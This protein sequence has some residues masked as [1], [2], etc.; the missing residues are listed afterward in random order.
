MR[1]SVGADLAGGHRR[2]VLSI[3]AAHLPQ[4]SMAWVFGSR[5]SG[6]ARPLSDLDLA[7]DAGRR[8]TLDE[9]AELA[10]AF[11]ESDLP[12]RVDVVDWRGI[13]ERFRQTIAAERQELGGSLATT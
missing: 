12:Y 9:I 3:L 8:L 13:D 7:I 10:E 2:L 4:G 6:R 5:A 1:R 11:T